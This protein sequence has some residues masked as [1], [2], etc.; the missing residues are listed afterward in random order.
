VA[1]DS[2]IPDNKKLFFF[3]SN[4]NQVSLLS[5]SLFITSIAS[6]SNGNCYYAGNDQEAVLIDAGVSCR[7][8]E[9]RMQ[10]LGLSMQ[11]VKAL[12]ISHEHSDHIRGVPVLAKKYRLPVYITLTTLM[13]GGLSLD[14]SLVVPFLAYEPIRIG[15]LSVTAFPKFHDASDPYSFIVS[16]KEIRVGVFTDIG[17]PCQHVI[18][19]F[20][21]CHA[22]FLE[23][24]YDEDM[25]EKGQYPYYLKRRIRGGHGH[26]SNREALELFNTYRPSNMSHLVLSHLSG[27]NN[28]P[29]LV[30][31]TF[32]PHAGTT[33]IIV[34]SRH[35]ETP[36]FHIRTR[37]SELNTM[38][39]SNHTGTAQLQLF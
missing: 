34:A 3:K 30:A 31:R 35:E 17:K 27:N 1:I 22:A 18:S 23:S 10:R 26:L 38:H 15:A 16:C 2:L 8:I 29:H 9:K 13:H 37:L 14:K 32:S 19:H 12:F 33:K 5:M 25:L 24:N 6:G 28:C 20:Q 39:Y 36:V 21:Q 4:R 11:K 7:E